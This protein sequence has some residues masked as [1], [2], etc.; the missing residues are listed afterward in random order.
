[1]SAKKTTAK[2]TTAKKT[3]AKKTTA[4]KTT[5]KKVAPQR[6]PSAPK[7]TTAVGGEL[8]QSSAI[9]RT[10][11]R[12]LAEARYTGAIKLPLFD[13][14]FYGVWLFGKQAVRLM[15][16][17][18]LGGETRTKDSLAHTMRGRSIAAASVAADTAFVESLARTLDGVVESSRVDRPYHPFAVYGT[19]QK[20]SDFFGLLVV[21][22]VNYGLVRWLESG[23]EWKLREIT[24]RPFFTMD[25]EEGESIDEYYGSREVKAITAATEMLRER[26]GKIYKLSLCEGEGGRRAVVTYPVFYFGVSPLGNVTGVFTLRRDD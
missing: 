5:A 15:K 4:K 23:E 3:T 7:K 6:S 24:K 10:L 1:M 8:T 2:K 14:D 16:A 11:T 22:G 17:K 12:T 19:G 20:K 13:S 18:P 26:C 25:L 9:D 21:G